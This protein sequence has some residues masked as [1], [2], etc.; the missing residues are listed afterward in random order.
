M[1][2]SENQFSHT[3]AASSTSGRAKR[4]FLSVLLATATFF[5][6]CEGS[7][8][9]AVHYE[10]TWES[11][12]QH[13][14]P[15][16]FENAVFG[17]YFHW[18]LYSVNGQ[19]LFYGMHM[20]EKGSGTYNYHVQHYGDPVTKFGYKDFIPLFKAEKWDPNGWAELFE[21]A[22]AD[23][24][25]PCAEHH[26]GFSMWDTKYNK[27]NAMTMGPHRDI[28]G[29]M[30][31][32]VRAHHMKTVAT[33]HHCRNWSNF[34]HGR[35]LC[36]EGVDVNDPA[37]ADLYGPIHQPEDN[38]FKN[39][40]TTP[41]YQETYANKIIEV[42]D[43]YRPDQVWLEDLFPVFIDTDKYVR[44]MIAHYFNSAESWGKEVMVTHKHNDLPL[45][46]SELDHEQGWG[47][48]ADP[49]PRRWQA[50]TSFPGCGWSYSSRINMTDEQ[51]DRGANTL[52]DSIV[53]RVSKNGVTL[54]SLTPKGDGTIP[55]YQVK[56]LIKLGDWMSVNKVALYGAHCR[57]PCSAG[58]LR[59]TEK[60]PYLYAI[61]LTKPNA[62]EVI[63]GVTPVQGS[64]IRMLGSDKPL[65]WHQA[66][67]DV[68][69]DKI[70]DPLPCDYAWTFKIQVK[71][72]NN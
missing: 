41:G 58:T 5:G 36:P 30:L 11:L 72:E 12:A 71:A 21:K 13:S 70:P 1:I 61:D 24:A 38:L 46:C 14:T 43:K 7:Y 51:I 9:A 22:G 42:I 33:F 44:P 62:G 10:A 48:K 17:I 55:E 60:G 28:V 15:K 6:L 40:K 53:S 59:F 18:G 16:W 25:G 68:I 8:G 54:L 26:D 19:D 3:G 64:E 4:H 63:P 47:E 57:M 65:T 69:I 39:I 20:Y 34:M 52:V 50:D 32:A 66:G 45:A 35:R 49:Q 27:F 37:Y 56:M 29:E 31:Q 67:A 2:N 23:F